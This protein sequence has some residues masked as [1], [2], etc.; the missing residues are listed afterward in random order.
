[1]ALRD[2]SRLERSTLRGIGE[3]GRAWVAAYAD[4]SRIM[5]ELAARI[6]ALE[7]QKGPHRASL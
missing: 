3:R 6:S 1:M 2:L 7:S 4:R 5:A